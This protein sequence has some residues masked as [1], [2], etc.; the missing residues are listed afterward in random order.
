[1]L[2]V[3]AFQNVVH[4]ENGA[5]VVE[6]RLTT[7]RESFSPSNEIS[8]VREVAMRRSKRQMQTST[9]ELPEPVPGA[10]QVSVDHIIA[11]EK[12]SEVMKVRCQPSTLPCLRTVIHDVLQ[13]THHVAL[14]M[15]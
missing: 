14:L 15:L 13:G 11:A 6:K 7:G 3:G 1:M 12:M 5:A 4:A 8:E 9:L 2:V 10:R